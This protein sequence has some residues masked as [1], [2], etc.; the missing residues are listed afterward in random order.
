M[1]L[2]L[3]LF[4]LAGA[5]ASLRFSPFCWR[6]RLAL[7]HKGLPVETVAWRFTEKEA[8]APSG[9]G[10][11]PVLVDGGTWLCESWRIAEYLDEK[12][13]DRPSLFGSIHGH[14]LARFVNEWTNVA[15]HPALARVIVP[16]I[17][18][19]LH[20]KDR[21]YFLRT[22]EA[23][24]GCTL[25]ALAAGR[26]EALAALRRTLVPLGRTLGE[27]PFL[28]GDAP[29]YADHIAFGAFQW[30]R[31]VSDIALLAPGDPIEAWV[32]RMLDAYGGLAR[33]APRAAG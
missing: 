9:Q 33:S 1:S 10:K 20:D 16:D 2:P 5:D 19:I 12:Y 18:A 13:P 32:E 23:A 6:I 14:A 8:I 30:A 21:E 17:P 15:L 7:A 27:Q 4:D 31:T 24:F 25:D 22:R 3:R 29:N 11:V 28:A 26:G